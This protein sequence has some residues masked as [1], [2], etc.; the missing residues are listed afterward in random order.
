MLT[1]TDEIQLLD[2]I[3]D[4]VPEIVI[5]VAGSA[6]RISFPFQFNYGDFTFPVALL[7]SALAS[8]GFPVKGFPIYS[9]ARSNR[10]FFKKPLSIRFLT[11]RATPKAP[12]RPGSGGTMIGFPT[13][14]AM[15]SGTA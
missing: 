11:S 9:L 1:D 15:A 6:E 5:P 8:E 7:L 14:E 4:V 2:F 13:R 12:I 3:P 10:S